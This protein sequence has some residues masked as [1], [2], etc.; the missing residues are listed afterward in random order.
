MFE[1][2]ELRRGSKNG[3]Q[4]DIMCL[5]E[6]GL[7]DLFTILSSIVNI[8]TAGDLIWSFDE[9]ENLPFDNEQDTHMSSEHL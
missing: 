2:S 6:I 4:K 5:K 8:I 3:P 9:K 1:W 7:R